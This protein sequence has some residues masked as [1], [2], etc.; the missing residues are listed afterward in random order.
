MFQR[1]RPTLST[2]YTPM[3]ELPPTRRPPPPMPQVRN[4]QCVAVAELAKAASRAGAAWSKAQLVD[5]LRSA[6]FWLDEAKRELA[7]APNNDP[8]PR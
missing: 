3:P 8:H 4:A 5:A 2:G 1:K 7:G 6:R